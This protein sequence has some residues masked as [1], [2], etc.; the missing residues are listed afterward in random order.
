MPLQAERHVGSTAVHAVWL[1]MLGTLEETLLSKK[2]KLME[3]VTIG[4][5]QGQGQ[6]C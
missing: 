4:Q 5:G 1:G 2:H 3:K 6:V